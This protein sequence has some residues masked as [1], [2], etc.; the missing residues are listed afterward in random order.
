MDMNRGYIPYV[1]IIG[2]SAHRAT[3]TQ[4]EGESM[5]WQPTVG[6]VRRAKWVSKEEMEDR[7]KNG[8]CLRCGSNEHH[9]KRCPYLPARR[10]GGA[11]T[12]NR[13]QAATTTQPRIPPVLD[14][15]NPVEVTKN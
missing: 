5:D 11:N 15:E 14:D 8:N 2:S 4:A 7:R 3:T 9:V 13:P 12:T 1:C 10:P 6:S